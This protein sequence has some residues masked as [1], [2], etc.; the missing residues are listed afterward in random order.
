MKITLIEP[1]MIKRPD[2]SEKP[3]FCFQP[4][5]LGWLAGITP[6][7]IEVEVLD[8]RFDRIDYD[9]PTDM[10]GISVK[11]FTARR[12]YEIAAEY[13]QRGVKVVL[14]GHHPSLIPEEALEHADAIVTGE[15]EPVW[16]KLLSDLSR[17]E[18]R[19]VYRGEVAKQ[20]PR[21]CANRAVFASRKYI[22]ITMIETSRGCPYNCSFCSVT[23][24]F[25]HTYRQR[26]PESIVREIEEQG[27]GKIFFVDDNIVGDLESAKALFRALI[28][29][30]VQWISQ[31]SISMAGDPDLLELMQRSGCAGVLVGLESL[32]PQSLKQIRKGWNAKQ[33]YAESL[34]MVREHGIAMVGSFMT[35]LDDDR[36][37]SLDATLEFAVEQK[38]FAAI[39]NLLVPYPGTDLY[40][41]FES[42]GRLLHPRWWLDPA[43]AYGKVPFRPRHFAPDELAEK[44][45]ELYRRF[46]GMNSILQRIFDIDANTRDPWHLFTY[47]ALNL[48]AYKQELQRQGKSLGSDQSTS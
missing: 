27:E 17:R 20:Y 21:G 41:A 45:L 19:Q 42:N 44:R 14:G 4:L 36:P 10:V 13:R 11:T 35:G 28:P 2:F 46:Y 29:L 33:S 39:F 38:L 23:K 3:M 26:R 31:A 8:D 18:L 15:A 48:S 5:T 22:P 6:P 7:S 37:E 32:A 1:A 24:F 16:E 30:K 47:L 25:D 12:A 9:R 43:Y 40:K 34:R